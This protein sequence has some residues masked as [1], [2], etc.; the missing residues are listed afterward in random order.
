M[1]ID[2]HHVPQFHV[3]KSTEFEDGFW[4]R[5]DVSHSGNRSLLVPPAWVPLCGG[6]PDH[7]HLVLC[8]IRPLDCC[9]TLRLPAASLCLA[10][11]GFPTWHSAQMTE[12]VKNC[13]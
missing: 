7:Y 13:N 12:I 6:I 3:A 5:F 4:G 1:T 9:T 10:Y 8:L 11:P 2:L